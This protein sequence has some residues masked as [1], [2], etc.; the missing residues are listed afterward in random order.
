MIKNTKQKHIKKP[1]WLKVN[2]FSGEKYMNV[3]KILNSCGVNTVC[4]EA[5]CPN[6]GTC[7]NEN[8]ATF[9]ILG[10]VCSRHCK[11]CNVSSGCP[12]EIDKDEINGIAE[13]VSR[14]DLKYVVITSVTRD[15]LD[16]GGSQHFADCI[17]KIK[18]VNPNTHIEALISDFNGD[19]NAVHGV[20]DSPLTVIGHNVETVPS[21]YDKIRPEAKY[22]QSLN[23][24]AE[25]KKYRPELISKSGMMLGLGETKE[26]V[27]SVMQDLRNMDCDI[28]TIGQYLRP[29]KL[30]HPVVEYI[31]PNIFAEY[32]K[33]GLEMGF[34]YV[35]SSPLTRSSYLAHRAYSS[36]IE[37]K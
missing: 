8:T 21:L 36:I 17:S 19:I 2:A 10:K 1:E 33:I 18:E 26:Q 15:D 12:Q 14:L 7:F 23:V 9:I 27:A 3:K 6:R 4:D 30:H 24:I 35:E 34:K 32:K 22:T 16:D 20:L 11:F 25:F 31:H 28:L 37:D 13:A 29:S 5:L